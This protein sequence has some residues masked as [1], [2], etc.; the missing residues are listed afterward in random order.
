[1]RGVEISIILVKFEESQNDCKMR[2]TY[3]EDEKENLI[4]KVKDYFIYIG[5]VKE[6][7]FFPNDISYCIDFCETDFDREC[8]CGNEKD[9]EMDVCEEC[10]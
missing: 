10:L 2:V 1:M 6:I 8:A 3:W 4:N 5:N 9:P 7:V